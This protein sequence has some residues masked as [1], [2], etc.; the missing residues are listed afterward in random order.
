MSKPKQRNILITGA[1]APIGER[2]VKQLLDDTNVGNILAV[3]GEPVESV[4]LPKHKSLTVIQ[5][6]L[7]KPRRVH[8][9]LFGP[10]KELEIDTVLHQGLH[11]S[12]W[13]EGTSVHAFNVE[14]LRSILELSERH[15]TIKRL[16]VRSSASVYQVQRDLPVL[17]GERH[18]LNMAPGAPQWI[19]DRVAADVEACTRMGVA[20]LQIAVL[21]MTEVLAIGTG[22]QLFDYLESPV[23]LRPAGYDPMVNLL[24]MTD[25]V[26]AL[27]KAAL[28]D[29]E[30]VFNIS[31]VD[32]LPISVAIKRWGRLGVPV[33][34][35]II[36]PLYR[37]RR[38]FTGREFR[39]GM[40][41]RRFHFSGVLDGN[42]ARKHLDFIPSSPINW[43]VDL[44][45][46]ESSL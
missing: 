7:R 4:G 2:L 30:G 17:I 23:C 12:A 37:A 29:A 18:P 8:D 28:C 38:R 42:R 27:A 25:A 35:A 41:R 15:P 22:S 11:R 13:E 26:N 33:P 44:N 34:G 36:S 16:V 24:S 40:N 6:D 32:T 21:R 9:L 10:A 14:A 46:V 39:Y 31:G 20:N 19:R 3:V 5:V 43:P 1:S 45:G